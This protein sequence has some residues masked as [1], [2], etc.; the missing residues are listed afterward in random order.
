ME[1]TLS[2]TD[3][4]LLALLW[5]YM[6]RDLEHADRVRTGYGT[7]TQYGLCRCIEAIMMRQKMGG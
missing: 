3:K 1:T 2:D 5:A 4:E 7:K 6:K